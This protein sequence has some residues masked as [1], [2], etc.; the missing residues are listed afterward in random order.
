MRWLLQTERQGVQVAHGARLASS[1]LMVRRV[2]A[3]CGVV[4]LFGAGCLTAES[5]PSPVLNFT[6]AENSTAERTGEAQDPWTRAECQDAFVRN[7]RWCDTWT[8]KTR[9][10]CYGV[11][12][13]LHVACVKGAE[14]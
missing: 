1:C 2:G 3:V 10:T 14:D 4:A 5:D 9:P 11:M 8:V 12:A 6:A 13:G 7:I